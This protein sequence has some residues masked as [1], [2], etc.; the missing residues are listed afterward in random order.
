MVYKGIEVSFRPLVHCTSLRPKS[1][2]LIT[3]DMATAPIIAVAD[4]I[5]V[6]HPLPYAESDSSDPT[7]GKAESD[8]SS[9]KETSTLND[10]KAPLAATTRPPS[11]LVDLFRFSRRKSQSFD[12]DSIA[13]QPSVFDDAEVAKYNAPHPKWEGLQHFDPSFRWT[14]REE[15]ALVRKMDL[16]VAACE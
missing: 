2:L 15:R 11:R 13:T 8:Q 16:R 3:A 7:L 1:S 5:L 10:T 9:V 12:L 6:A 4:P 14:W